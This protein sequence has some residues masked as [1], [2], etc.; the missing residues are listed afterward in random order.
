MDNK[1]KKRL[2]SILDSIPALKKILAS[3]DPLEKKRKKIREMLNTMLIKTYDDNPSL[4]S[5]SWVMTRDAILVFRNIISRR[6]EKIAEYSFLGYL[7]DLIH[8]GKISSKNPPTPGFF[9]E[10]SQSCEDTSLTG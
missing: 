4:P 8:D 7:N 3:A 6:S 5:L 1:A 9:S 10:L 2:L